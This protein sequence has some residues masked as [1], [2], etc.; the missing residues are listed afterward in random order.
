MRTHAQ[1]LPA[2]K[3]NWAA[4]IILVVVA[5]VVLA[6]AYLALAAILV[7]A[8]ALASPNLL[9]AG[10]MFGSSQAAHN[11]QRILGTE[12]TWFPMWTQISAMAA[13]SSPVPEAPAATDSQADR[14]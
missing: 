8:V 1:E 9:T 12:A 5:L 10:T 3:A 14:R 2:E 6:I 11:G 7:A 4:R 13:T